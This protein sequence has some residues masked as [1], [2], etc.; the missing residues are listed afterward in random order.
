M[1]GLLATAVLAISL[2]GSGKPA[3]AVS[4]GVQNDVDTGI[5]GNTWAFDTYTRGVRVWRTGSGRF[6]AAST[7]N[8]TFSS[9]EG[10]SPGGRSKLPAG[11]LG[12]FKG[13]S[14][15]TFR[16][17]L[18]VHGAPLRGFLGVKDF[19]CTSADAKGQ[20]V[21]TWDWIDDYFANVTQFRYTGYSFAYH[22]TQN[23]TGTF[24]DR[25]VNG[26]VKYTG[27]IKAARPKPRR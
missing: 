20:C 13:T 25:L 5:R 2:C 22:A 21:G 12:T 6:C 7:Y 19:A 14:V 3:I 15:T 9:I 4:Y 17:K 23:G 10:T 16:G 26:K 11:V 1:G 18:S 8:G 27:D 24:A